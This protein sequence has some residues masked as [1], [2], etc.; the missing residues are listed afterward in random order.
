MDYNNIIG[1]LEVTPEG[2]VVNVDSLRVAYSDSLKSVTISFGI[3]ETFI[4]HVAHRCDL[5]NGEM[6]TIPNILVKLP[7]NLAFK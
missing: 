4:H 1:K 2:T 5:P 3:G 6:L 7:V